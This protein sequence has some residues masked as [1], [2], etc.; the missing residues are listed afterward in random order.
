M[1]V[2]G[3]TMIPTAKAGHP[4]PVGPSEETT[5]VAADN[6]LLITTAVAQKDLLGSIVILATVH[7][8][9]IGDPDICQGYAQ[10]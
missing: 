4:S 10:P 3:E 9:K 1:A 7:P 8:R 2:A 6:N 5:T